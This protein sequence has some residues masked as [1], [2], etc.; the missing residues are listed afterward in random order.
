MNPLNQELTKVP[1]KIRCNDDEMFG[2][3]QHGHGAHP[4][5]PGDA[6]DIRLDTGKVVKMSS[7]LIE[8]TADELELEKAIIA[9]WEMRCPVCVGQGEVYTQEPNEFGGILHKIALCE[10]CGTTGL[11]QIEEGVTNG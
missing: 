9:H 8:R 1:V 7:A 10:E 3:V 2:R 4:D 6:V 5:D 11:R